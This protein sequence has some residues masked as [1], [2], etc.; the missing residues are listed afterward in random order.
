[1]PRE[2]RQQRK[3]LRGL[4]QLVGSMRGER[5]LFEP[6]RFALELDMKWESVARAIRQLVQL[7][8]VDYVPPFRGRAIHMLAAD[9]SFQELEIDFAELYRRQQAER[10]KLDTMIR[11]ASTRRCRQLEILEY[12]GDDNRY[13]CNRCDNC[14]NQ[15]AENRLPRPAGKKANPDACLYAAQVTLS[16]AARTENRFGKTMVAQMLTGSSSR[17]IQKNGLHKLSTFGLL[18]GLRQTDVVTLINWLI[19]H[20]FLKQSEQTRFRPVLNVTD[21]GRALM[22][23]KVEFELSQ[24]IPA[25]IVESIS[26]RLAHKKPVRSSIGQAVETASPG[27]SPVAH[28]AADDKSELTELPDG[29]LEPVQPPSQTG[30]EP[31]QPPLSPDPSSA[32]PGLPLPDETAE[33]GPVQPSYYWTWKLFADGYS[34]GEVAQVRQLDSAALSDHLIRAAENGL[35]IDREWMLNRAEIETLESLVE[36]HPGDSISRLVELRPPGITPQQLFIFLKANARG[37]D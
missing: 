2:A 26:L 30:T 1:L 34:W 9:K 11:F 3:V 27:S 19:D 35:E 12:F 23:G 29:W 7:E 15:S 32:A 16:G 21:S 4:E 36:S 31:I 13:P 37:T 24:R 20:G 14:Q 8:G 10:D 22:K 33:D 5:I 28:E 25:S 18:S 17:K 6:K